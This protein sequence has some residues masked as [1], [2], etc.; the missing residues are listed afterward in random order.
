LV[1]TPYEPTAKIL[2]QR[3]FGESISDYH[4]LKK[5][6]KEE[7]VDGHIFIT[8]LAFHLWKWVPEKLDGSGDRRD[9]TIIRRLLETHC[10]STLIVTRADGS[11]HHQRKAG[12]AEAQQRKIYNELAIET[13]KL[14]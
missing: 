9:W 7:R 13:S 5:D 8:M 4:K 2:H 1:V 12:R 11:I 14:I 3:N 10:Y 6:Q